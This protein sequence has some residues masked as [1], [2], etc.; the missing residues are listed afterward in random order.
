[1][2]G[3]IARFASF[4]TLRKGRAFFCSKIMQNKSLRL[5]G[6]L[7]RLRPM[8][9]TAITLRVSAAVAE[10]LRKDAAQNFRS[11]SAHLRAILTKQIQKTQ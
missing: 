8:K 4:N 5:R 10:A 6:T 2:T 3:Y 1:M 11:L 9:T 7:K